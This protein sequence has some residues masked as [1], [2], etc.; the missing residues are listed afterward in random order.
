MFDILLERVSFQSW[1]KQT[2]KVL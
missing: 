2:L 1:L